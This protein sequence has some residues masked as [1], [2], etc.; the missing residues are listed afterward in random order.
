MLFHPS[1]KVRKAVFSDIDFIYSLVALNTESNI[2]IDKFETHLKQKLKTSGFYIFILEEQ[3]IKIEKAGLLIASESQ[4]L[5]D[6]WPIIEIQE[7]FIVPKYRKIGAADFLFNYV[8]QFSKEKKAYKL[9]VNCKINSTLNQ[10]FYT[11]RG[12][13]IAKKQYTKPVY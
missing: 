8:E 2:G 4:Q 5:V 6:A 7:F 13:K 10:N 12:F 11:D 1:Y 9:K 3:K